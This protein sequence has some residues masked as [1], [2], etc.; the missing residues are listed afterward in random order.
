MAEE[1]KPVTIRYT[2]RA[3][4]LDSL[5]RRPVISIEVTRATF[6]AIK[7]AHHDVFL[8]GGWHDFD[9]VKSRNLGHRDREIAGVCAEIKEQQARYDGWKQTHRWATGEWAPLPMS[10][11]EHN[12]AA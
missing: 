8:A 1:T 6:D 5:G 4:A 11:H 2:D 10:L 7:A 12:S 3:G 9:W